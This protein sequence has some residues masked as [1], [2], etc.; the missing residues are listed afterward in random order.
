M[1]NIWAF[2]KLHEGTTYHASFDM[3]PLDQENVTVAVFT[4]TVTE[5]QSPTD[6]HQKT[7]TIK[8]NTTHLSL[9]FPEGLIFAG[10]KPIGTCL[11]A[12]LVGVAIKTITE[13]LSG[14]MTDFLKCL[15]S[16]GLTTTQEAVDCAMGCFGA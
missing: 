7:F 12:C 11:A 8:V 14:D 5:A 9:E 6:K 1:S 3:N 15:G 4:M 10:L 13:C 16:K 2:S